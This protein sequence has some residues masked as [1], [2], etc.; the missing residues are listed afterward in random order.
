VPTPPSKPAF[1]HGID[2]SYAQGTIDWD[3]VAK[4]S[5]VKFVYSRATYGTNPDDDD[6]AF[7]QRNHDECKRLGIPFGAY[8][9]FLFGQDGVAQAQHFL[10]QIDGRYGTLRAM[11]DV[12][13]S[14]GLGDSTQDMIDGLDAFRNLV[15][16]E[17]G[18]PIIFY[19][20]ADTWNVNLGGRDD[21]AGHQLWISNF[22]DNPK[23]APALPNGFKDWTL[24]QYSNNG[25]I[26]VIGSA[27][28]ATHAVDL[29]V[30]NGVDLSVIQR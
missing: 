19:T 7:F 15:E 27:G 5:G 26:P 17:L 12:E 8:H 4:S 23:K 9:F 25:T 20:N 29:D 21:F 6:G 13:E 22:T 18:A 11:V 2:V 1:L 14:S 16:K 3:K 28:E 24:Y 30:L 10:Q